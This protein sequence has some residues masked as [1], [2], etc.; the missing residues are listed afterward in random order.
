M[1]K[2][3]QRYQKSFSFKSRIFLNYFGNFQGFY[4]NNKTIQKRCHFSNLIVFA[5]PNDESRNIVLISKIWQNI[6]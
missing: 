5:K 6:S 4:G 2:K 1:S 3:F